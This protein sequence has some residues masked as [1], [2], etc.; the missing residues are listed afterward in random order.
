MPA[1][2][3]VK[4][5]GE[6]PVYYRLPDDTVLGSA[7]LDLGT[8]TRL[9]AGGETPKTAFALDTLVGAAFSPA[10]ASRF[11]V[12]G[13]L[14]YSYVGFAEHF[15]TAGLGPMLR[16]KGPIYGDDRALSD[17]LWFGVVPRGLVG[18]ADGDLAVGLRTAAFLGWE[19][20]GLEVAHQ[21]IT[22]GTGSEQE[23][24]VAFTMYV[25]YPAR[26]R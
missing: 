4:E 23:I 13:E 22:R 14:G 3:E 17:Q 16:L 9:S 7:R 5:T 25:W 12:L 19:G 20:W 21:F 1:P 18:S 6:S 2:R 15:F 8:A 11:A 26:Y 10:R 24:H